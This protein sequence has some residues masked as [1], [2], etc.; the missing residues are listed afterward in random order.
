MLHMALLAALELDKMAGFDRLLGKH[1]KA[2][3]EICQCVLQR[4]SDGAV[5]MPREAISGV[6][7][8]PTLSR[9]HHDRQRYHDSACCSSN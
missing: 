9:K 6:I 1:I 3:E 4:Q 7:E 5:P 8:M 2:G